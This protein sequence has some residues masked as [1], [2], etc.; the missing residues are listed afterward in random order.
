MVPPRSSIRG[1][2]DHCEASE[3]H[4]PDNKQPAMIVKLTIITLKHGLLVGDILLDFLMDIDFK[5]EVVGCA[6]Y[7]EGMVSSTTTLTDNCVR[8]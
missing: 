3:A 6:Y 1:S 7:Y 5:V 8:E 4:D 2:D